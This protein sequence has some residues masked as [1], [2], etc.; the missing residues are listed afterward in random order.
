MLTNSQENAFSLILKWFKSGG[1]LFKL[2]GPAGSGKSYLITLIAEE[3]D[4]KKILLVTP[5]GKAANNLQK[6][7][8]QARTI[9]S[10]LYR[11]HDDDEE[12][13][14]VFFDKVEKVKRYAASDPKFELKSPNTL[15]N[16]GVDLVIIDEGSMV[17][18][19]MLQDLLT[20]DTPIL[21][22]GDPNQLNPVQDSMVF[23]QCDFYLQEIVRQAQ[24]SPIIWLSQQVLQGRLP[25]GWFGSSLIREGQPTEEE[26]RYADITLTDTNARREELNKRIRSL[27]FNREFGIHDWVLEG[28]QVI[29]RENCR[30]TSTKG[31]SLTNGTLGQVKTIHHKSGKRAEISLDCDDLGVFRFECSDD[32]LLFPKKSRPP[33]IELGYAL[34]VHLSQGS[35]WCNVVYDVSGRA[36]ARNRRALYTAITRAKESILVTV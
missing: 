24:D 21:L 17:G 7:G 26:L 22:V 32:P 16:E 9:H 23:N 18:G 3:L 36:G 34:T 10:V 12:E 2:G 13:E 30:E 28:D 33:K 8:L 27:N 35:E 29:C 20:F 19:L 11:C 15:H 1:K 5:T 4:N 14:K 31:F 25:T 6:S